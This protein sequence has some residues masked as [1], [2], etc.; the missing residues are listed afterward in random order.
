MNPSRVSSRIWSEWC[1]LFFNHR[2]QELSMIFL[3]LWAIWQVN[4]LLRF[5]Q[6]L[7][8]WSLNSF[9]EASVIQWLKFNTKLLSVSS[10]LL[11]V[12][13]STHKLKLCSHILIVFSLK[14][15][16]FSKRPRWTQTTL[17]LREFSKALV[18]LQ[19]PITS[20]NTITHSC[21]DS[22]KSLPWLL[23]ILLKRPT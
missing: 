3:W 8:I 14:S 12:S 16:H 19:Q 9:I 23:A 1:Y 2:I 13:N 10:T 15:Q 11:K 4:S 20:R 17:C 5:K 18:S 7:E 6:T 22:L 21:L